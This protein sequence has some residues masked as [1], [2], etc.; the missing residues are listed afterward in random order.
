MSQCTFLSTI[1]NQEECFKE[2]VF[3]HL[4]D[5]EGCPFKKIT[6][7]KNKKISEYFKYELLNLEESEEAVNIDGVYIEDENEEKYL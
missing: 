2:C 1:E 7:T 4:E 5:E 3:N 6:F